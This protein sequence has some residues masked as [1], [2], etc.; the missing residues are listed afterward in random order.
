VS[1]YI[2]HI[3]THTHTHTHTYIHTYIHT[4]THFNKQAAVPAAQ[5]VQHVA[6]GHPQQLQRLMH[7]LDTGGVEAAKRE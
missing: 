7:A 6:L 2:T 3:H 4:Y 1:E 5:V